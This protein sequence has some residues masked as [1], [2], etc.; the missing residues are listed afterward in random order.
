M[1]LSFS[2]TRLWMLTAFIKQ[3]VR[4]NNLINESFKIQV[5]NNIPLIREQPKHLDSWEDGE[6]PWIFIDDKDKK[7][8]D[9]STS[10][11]KPVIPPFVPLSPAQIAFLL[12]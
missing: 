7:G 8:S 2:L 12:I 10:V 6:I 9:N 5:P 1:F 11:R 3:I 4:P